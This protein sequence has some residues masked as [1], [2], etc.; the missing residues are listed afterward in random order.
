MF[1]CSELCIHFIC[2]PW[3]H[4]NTFV[5]YTYLYIFS[6]YILISFLIAICLYISYMQKKKPFNAFMFPILCYHIHAYNSTHFFV[7]FISRIFVQHALL[8]SVFFVLFHP[9]TS[10]TVLPFN[11]PPCFC[12]YGNK[13]KTY[14]KRKQKLFRHK[15]WYIFLTLQQIRFQQ[16]EAKMYLTWNLQKYTTLLEWWW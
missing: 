8:L 3:L 12:S 2:T 4:S 15:C 16:P 13:N 5:S 7:F 10:L 14:K 1:T 11:H 6:A 9:N